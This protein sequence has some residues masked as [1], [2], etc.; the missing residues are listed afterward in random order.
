MPVVWRGSQ[1]GRT[2]PEKKQGQF[3]GSQLV[4]P[5]MDWVECQS[6]FGSSWLL[7]A[8]TTTGHFLLESCARMVKLWGSRNTHQKKYVKPDPVGSPPQKWGYFI[9]DWVIFSAIIF[10]IKRA[11]SQC[12]AYLPPPSSDINLLLQHSPL[13]EIYSWSRNIWEER[14][15]ETMPSFST[16][17]SSHNSQFPLVNISD[18]REC[19]KVIMK[20]TPL[21][22]Q[23][24]FVLHLF[25]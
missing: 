3:W 1:R 12:K 18:I 8:M 22:L 10:A 6:W 2:R 15:A 7:R 5:H 23:R 25:W 19:S 21:T 11:Y 17:T 20:V 24:L 9:C 4:W 14:L 13:L 16:H